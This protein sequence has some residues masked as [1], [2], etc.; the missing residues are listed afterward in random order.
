MVARGLAQQLSPYLYR[1]PLDE[2]GVSPRSPS[3]CVPSGLVGVSQCV[4][5]TYGRVH[6]KMKGLDLNRHR[7][8]W[9]WRKY[10]NKTHVVVKFDLQFRPRLSKCY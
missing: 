6:V 2:A 1:L 10:V 3:F 7:D 4:I 8:K 5:T 9:S